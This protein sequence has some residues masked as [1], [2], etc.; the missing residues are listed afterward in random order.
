V[1]INLLARAVRSEEQRDNACLVVG[2][3]TGELGLIFQC[4][5]AEPDE[6]DVALGMDTHCLVTTDGGCA[7]GCV[8][9]IAFDGDRLRIVLDPAALDDLELD[10]ARIE[11]T[12]ALSEGTVAELRA[13]LRR[14]LDYG[15][16]DARPTTIGL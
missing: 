13:G 5:L 15:R 2:V 4:G 11:V 14:V 10:E 1:P 16:A 8:E 3:D 9:E 12:L 6:Q 7:Y